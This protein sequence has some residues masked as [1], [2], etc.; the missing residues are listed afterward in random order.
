MWII[1]G[2]TT[3]VKDLGVVAEYCPWCEKITPCVVQVVSEED[4]VLFVKM[5]EAAKEYSCLC[6][7]CGGSFP[8][9][10]WRYPSL[11]PV[12]EVAGLSLEDLLTRTN[13]GLTARVELKQQ[14]IAL[15]GDDRFTT[16]YEH[17]EGIRPGELHARLLQQLL[18]WSRLKV[19][20]RI[21]LVQ[22][23]DAYARAW[24]LA[25]Q[26]A[27]RFPEHAGCLPAFLV[28][29]AIWSAFHWAPL[30]RSLLWGTGT[31]LAGCGAGVLIAQLLL[32]RQV[33]RWTRKVLIPEAQRANVSLSCFLSVVDDLPATRYRILDEL[34]P[35]AEVVGVDRQ[36]RWAT[37]FRFLD[38][39][40][41]VKD[42][43]DII[44]GVLARDG[45]L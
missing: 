42:Q 27:P 35:A 36:G 13:P 44:R 3:E 40:W 23:V 24:Q 25:R 26:I 17:L 34:W 18:S 22:Q 29:L 10:L 11:V 12:Q 5:F 19:E 9:Q 15:G 28:A 8:C 21:E 41:P 4:H 14:I 7:V 32:G 20:Q 43:L 1:W 45:K 30:V 31:V 16:A 37:Q 6:R 38:D 2:K 33:R 39:L